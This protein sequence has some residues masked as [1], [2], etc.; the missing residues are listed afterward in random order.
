M[1]RFLRG[2]FFL[3]ASSW[4]CPGATIGAG[5]LLEVRLD[6]SLT[7]YSSKRGAEVHVTLIAPVHAAGDILV[8]QGSALR[9]TLTDVKRI[10]WGLRHLRASM[11]IGFDTLEL[12]DGTSHAIHTRLVS[13]D[14]ARETVDGQGRIVGIRATA[15]MGYRAAGI[16]RNIFCWDPLLQLVLAGSTA[17]VLNFPEAEIHF[18]AGTEMR[19]ALT[20]PLVLD[21][22]WSTPLPR[23]A[24]SEE[25][26]REIFNQLRA[27]TWRT[28]TQGSSKPADFVN[29]VFLG[30]PEWAE[31]A[32]AAAGWVQADRLSRGTGWKT[33]HS[34][35]EARPYARAPMSP[36]LLDENPALL[37][38]SKSLN[39]YSRRHH[40][41]IFRQPE[42]WNGRPVLAAASTQ[43]LAVTVSLSNRRLIHVIDR[44]IDNERA[45]IVND[46]VYTGCVDAAELM[47]RPWVP[48]KARIATGEEI[49]TDGAVAVIEL[50]PCRSPYRTLDS[51]PPAQIS[52][53]WFQRLS[54]QIFLTVGNDFTANNP[55]YQSGKG[56]QF[57]FRRMLGKEDRTQPVRASLLQLPPQ[58]T[59]VNPSALP[60]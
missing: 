28:T 39:N 54:R 34:F 1:K 6:H 21:T 24:T 53:G 15:P 35:A 32:F 49:Q 48:S 31:R 45:K 40:L 10:G 7:S 58:T 20:Q 27:M 18:P 57:L 30:E 55:I 2:L 42:T 38:F 36:M 12:P 14:N 19:L 41:R 8:P 29:L 5:T 13:V 25:N 16:A 37:Q 46:L 23:I 11:R 26:R 44:N 4:A 17:S 56:M 43:D 59:E 50:N 51:G 33:F 52:G 60:D 3:C 9:G 47:L 22:T